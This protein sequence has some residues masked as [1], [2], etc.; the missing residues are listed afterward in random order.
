MAGVCCQS[1]IQP[2]CMARA[3]RRA[4]ASGAGSWG[5]GRGCAPG[6]V[7]WAV[8]QPGVEG[9]PADGGQRG[10]RDPGQVADGAGVAVGGGQHLG[11][12]VERGALAGQRYAA[13]DAER[14]VDDE[15]G[16]VVGRDG[17]VERGQRG[18]HGRDGRVA[19]PA[20]LGQGQDQHGGEQRG[21]AGPQRVDGGAGQQRRGHE[22][23]QRDPGGLA[24]AG[25]PGDA[26]EPGVGQDRRDPHAVPGLG[27]GH[28]DRGCR[29]SASIPAPARRRRPTAAPAARRCAA[30]AT[31]SARTPPARTAPGRTR[32]SR[33]SAP[34][35]RSRRR[36]S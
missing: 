3:S 23:E 15:G 18:G 24:E 6:L 2:M 33:R 36:G 8:E 16:G 29:S 7:C 11:L 31:R 32:E 14:D 25:Q 35:R 4:A 9:V 10:G 30:A 13:A 21:R 34:G 19:G 22:G 26:D 12:G 27:G 1:S 20:G 5:G 28:V 17:G